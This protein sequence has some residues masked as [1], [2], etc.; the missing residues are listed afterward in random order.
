MT[1]V[2]K[3]VKEKFTYIK[4]FNFN[5]FHGIGLILLYLKKMTFD[6]FLALFCFEMPPKC[7]TQ[8]N[9]G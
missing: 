4:V 3:S 8:N 1:F 6:C 9:D 5:S 2:K 7:A